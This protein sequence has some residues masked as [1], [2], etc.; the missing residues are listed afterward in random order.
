MIDEERF[1]CILFMNSD[2]FVCIFVKVVY[3]L[4]FTGYFRFQIGVKR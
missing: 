4:F 1:D 3:L 2:A